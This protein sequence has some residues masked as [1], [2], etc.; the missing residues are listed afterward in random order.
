MLATEVPSAKQQSF[1]AHNP[2]DL[3]LVSFSDQ[4]I[5]LANAFEQ[6]VQAERAGGFRE[7]S[8]NALHNYWHKV[9]KGYGLD[10]NCAEFSLDE[11]KLPEGI[12]KLD[13]LSALE[14]WV[15]DNGKN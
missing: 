3:A 8:V 4:P 11:G 6:P 7:P 12:A 9:H 14:K 10:E 15:R 13:T 5:S 2:A 1:A